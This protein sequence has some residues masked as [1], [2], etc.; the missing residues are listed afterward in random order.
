MSISNSPVSLLVLAMLTLVAQ[1]HA[2]TPDEDPF[3]AE[4]RK[5]FKYSKIPSVDMLRLEKTWNCRWGIAAPGDMSRDQGDFFK[6]TQLSATLLVNKGELPEYNPEIVLT[7][8]GWAGSFKAEHP[9]PTCNPLAGRYDL[10]VTNAGD[11]IVE[12]AVKFK[13]PCKPYP[14]AV[15]SQV[16]PAYTTLGYFICPAQSVHD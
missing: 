14:G 1:A 16:D 15:V 7:S 3:I 2:G 5:E 10:R 12:S 6:L 11:L 9:N 4:L 8:S 13:S